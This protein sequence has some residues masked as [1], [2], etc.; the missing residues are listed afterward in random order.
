MMATIT[1]VHLADLHHLSSNPQSKTRPVTYIML[2]LL[3]YLV[4]ILYWQQVS[5]KSCLK[6]TYSEKATNFCEIFTLLL[7][8]TTSDK[9]KEKILQYF[10]AF[11]EYMNFT[12][13]LLNKI[14]LPPYLKSYTLPECFD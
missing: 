6:F 8:G 12:L 13:H 1:C 14:C 3:H 7:T 10:V 2:M 9:S 4:S 5:K 11:S